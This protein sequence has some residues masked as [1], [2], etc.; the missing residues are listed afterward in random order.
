MPEATTIDHGEIAV[1]HL[2]DKYRRP[3]I[4]A[5][6]RALASAYQEADDVAVRLPEETLGLDSA[7]GVQLLALA[8]LVGAPI[9]GDEDSIRILAKTWLRRNRSRGTI[10]DLIETTALVAQDFVV[11]EIFPA[12]VV[13]LIYSFAADLAAT[14]AYVLQGVRAAGVGGGV[15]AS[16]VAKDSTFQ[17]SSVAG[18]LQSSTDRGYGHGQYAGLFP[19]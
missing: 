7:V 8:D 14:L 16:E 2:T 3:N 13:V 11:S 6:V 15:V 5:L 17:F 10:N 4:E 12:N 18:T 19:A 1:G 9:F